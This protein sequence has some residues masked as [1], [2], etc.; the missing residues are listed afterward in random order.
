M[1]CEVCGEHDY[2]IHANRYRGKICDRCNK[3]GDLSD[4]F[5][6]YEFAC[7][8]GCEFDDVDE[9]HVEQLQK[10]RD[11][12][13]VYMP[14]ISGCRCAEHNEA[15]GGSETSDHLTGEGSDVGVTNSRDRFLI[16]KAAFALD[17]TRIAVAKTFI[18][19]GTSI[20]NTQDVMW[21]Y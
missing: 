13:G 7:K 19:L 21:V 11:L 4:N 15:V 6:R 16:C 12:S 3:M 20:V 8:C 9:F 17:F 14:I 1:K 5:S 18:H 10:V 2:I